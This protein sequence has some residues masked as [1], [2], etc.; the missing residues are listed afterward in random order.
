[1]NSTEIADETRFLL[2]DPDKFFLSD[3]RL[4][5]ML[6]TAY[7]RFR[8]LAHEEYFERGYTP[9][10]LVSAIELDLTG[11]LFASQAVPVLP[12]DIQPALRFTRV[13]V[14]DPTTGTLREV[15]NPAPSFTTLRQIPPTSSLLATNANLAMTGIR[16]FLDGAVLR[17]SSPLTGTIDIRYIPSQPINWLSGIAPG[18]NLFIDNLVDYHDLICLFAASKYAMPNGQAS[19][20]I[21]SML[22]ARVV[23]MQRFFSQT[24]SGEGSRFVGDF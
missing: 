7:G 5:R 15:L 8:A 2:Q 11:L 10:P 14:V 18:A 22:A 3:Q 13:M 17:F 16:W 20:Q 6:A 23:E 9:T 12:G 1:M 21:Q 19:P 4:A 24:R